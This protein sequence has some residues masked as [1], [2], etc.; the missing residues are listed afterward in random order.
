MMRHLTLDGGYN[1]RDLG[2]YPTQDG[3]YTQMQI[4][5]RAG[6]LDKL[7]VTGR[8]QLI[9]FG[10]KT[11]IDLRDEW[12]AQSFPD[13]FAQSTEVKYYNVPLIGNSLSSDEHWKI[14]M[15][16]YNQLHELYA[17]YLNLCQPQVKAIVHAVAESTPAT[18]IHCH[19]GKDRTGLVT[20]LVL[21]AVGVP[22]ALI[23]EDYAHTNAQIT[24]LID[25]WREE[26]L[27][28]GQ[29][30]QRFEHDVDSAPETMVSTLNYLQE[31]YGGATNYLYPDC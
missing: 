21:A 19:A 2:G 11:I 16:S 24:F 22:A 5:I 30:M 3:H 18:L 9:D 10:V 20:A 27:K 28:R 17:I 14:A 26:A 25:Q 31:H 7:S 8:Q 13:I 4:L 1:V 23:A 12:E 29:D 15:K 6:N